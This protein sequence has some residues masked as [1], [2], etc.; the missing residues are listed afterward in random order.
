LNP[1]HL[2]AEGVQFNGQWQRHR[3]ET[4]I[5]RD[6]ERIEF[7]VHQRAT[8]SGSINCFGVLSVCAATAIE[9]HAFSMRFL[10]VRPPTLNKIKKHKEDLLQNVTEMSD[11]FM[12]GALADGV[13][14]VH[15]LP[16]C[17]L[18]STTCCSAL[19]QN[20]YSKQKP[21]R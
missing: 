18:V 16:G 21:A 13:I 11:Y 19:C 1:I 2:H 3:I 8:L 4:N 20:P 5:N 7:D 6:P 9:S 12:A 15:P 17:A 10:I 14:A